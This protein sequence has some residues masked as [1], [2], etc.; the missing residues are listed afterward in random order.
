MFDCPECH[1]D[2][3]KTECNPGVY[4]VCP[5]C[6]GRS[7]TVSLLRQLIPKGVVNKMWQAAWVGDYPRLRN[8]PACSNPMVEVPVGEGE[9]KFTLDVCI[10]CQTIWFDANEYESLPKKMRE[11]TFEERLPQAAREVVALNRVRQIQS[12]A[13]EG[14]EDSEAE[15]WHWIVGFFGVPVESEAQSLKS[16]PWATWITAILILIVS[17]ACFSDLQGWVNRFGLVPS[18][19]GRYSGITFITSFFIHGGIWHLLSNLYFFVVFGDNVEEWLGWKKFLLLLL[20]ASLLGDV[21]HTAI[22]LE[23]AIPCVGASGGISGILTFYALQFPRTK[24]RMLVRYF[25]K[26]GWVRI[27]AWVLF[28]VWLTLQGFGVKAQ[29]DGVSRISALAHVG[30]IVAGFVFWIISKKFASGRLFSGPV[31]YTKTNPDMFSAP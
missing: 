4:W 24:L 21:L 19:F 8:C 18:E 5:S 2:L 23:S 28:L 29:M 1:V 6:G 13:E 7:A 16:Y 11:L 31:D 17:V 14:W 9:A 10:I 26:F 12:E 25:Y 20:S 30:G 22:N 15:W 27:P 3:R